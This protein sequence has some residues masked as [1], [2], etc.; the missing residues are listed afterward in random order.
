MVLNLTPVPRH[1]YR[2]GVFEAG[3]YQEIMNTDAA[4]YGGSDMNNAGDV[5]SEK[6][7]AMGKKHSLSIHLPP[8][9]CLVF[10]LKP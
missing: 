1:D 9:S 2:L 3:K 6:I 4:T 7:A 8:L 5:A 10:A